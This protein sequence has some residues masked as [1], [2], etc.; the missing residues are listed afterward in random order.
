MYV[1][2]VVRHESQ[3]LQKD[4]NNFK[5]TDRFIRVYVITM[6]VLLE[7]LNI[8]INVIRSF[9]RLFSGTCQTSMSAPIIFNW[10]LT[11]SH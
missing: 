7:H 4:T 5:K 2:E 1:M 9:L 11:K 10:L 8:Y 3:F 6:T